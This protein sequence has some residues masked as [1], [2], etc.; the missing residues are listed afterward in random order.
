[1]LPGRT[2][3]TTT[4]TQSVGLQDQ[5]DTTRRIRRSSMAIPSVGVDRS[6]R[7]L[8]RTARSH[9]AAAPHIRALPAHHI[10]RKRPLHH[11]ASPQL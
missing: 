1:M 9:I 6:A 3:Q 8:Q 2:A 5:N 4:H 7:T 11:G 10:A